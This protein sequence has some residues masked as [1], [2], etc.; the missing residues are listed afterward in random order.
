MNQ[1]LHDIGFSLLPVRSSLRLPTVPVL[2][3][4]A[5]LDYARMHIGLCMN[6][7]TVFPL[8]NCAASVTWYQT[9]VLL[10]QSLVARCTLSCLSWPAYTMVL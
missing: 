5:I 6:N 1:P 4:D 10:H 9:H 3:A 2:S 7:N 8:H